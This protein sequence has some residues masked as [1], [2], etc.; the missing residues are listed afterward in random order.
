MVTGQSG[1]ASGQ[2]G[3]TSGPS[4]SASGPSDGSPR[5]GD[6]SAHLEISGGDLRSGGHKQHIRLPV[7]GHTLRR[8]HWRVGH[9]QRPVRQTSDSNT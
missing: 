5:P 9:R 3:S 2:S 8:R 4:G 7:Y 6:G 1:S